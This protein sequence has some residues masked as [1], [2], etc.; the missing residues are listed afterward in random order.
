MTHR[1]HFGLLALATV[2]LAA[3]GQMEQESMSVRDAWANATPVGINIGAVYMEIVASN[4]DKLL[5]ARTTVA[6]R[7]EMHTSAEQNG[8]MT[9]RLLETVDL[10]AKKPFTFAPGGAHF[11]LLDLRQ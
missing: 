9:M 2:A 5:E 11:M 6:D 1:R 4:K 8:M 7:I 10:A 3:C